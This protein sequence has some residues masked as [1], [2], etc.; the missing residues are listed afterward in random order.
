MGFIGGLAEGFLSLGR[1]INKN[2]SGDD[3]Q[4]RDEGVVSSFMD[5][6]TVD[7]DDQT[8]LESAKRWEKEWNEYFESKLQRRQDEAEN[9]W[10]GN[11]ENNRNTVATFNE[12]P[13]A[14][15][16]IFESLETFLPVATRQNPE[17]VIGSDNTSDGEKFAGLTQELVV[18]LS[19]RLRYKLK[20]KQVARHWALYYHGFLKI[21]WSE[22]TDNI[23]FKV[24]RPQKLILDPRS[25]I[26]EGFYTG[27]Y[28]GER[29]KE[30]ASVLIE[31]YPNKAKF[32]KDLVNDKLATEVAYIEWWQD[33][34]VFWTLKGEVLNKVQNPHWNFDTVITQ[35]VVNDFGEESEVEQEVKGLNHFPTPRKPY[36]ALS[37]FNSGKRPHDDTSLI[38]QNL[39]VQDIIN[40][41]VIQID[42]NVDNMNL[43]YIISMKRAGLTKEQAASLARTLRRGGSAA[44]PDG[45][46]RAA[47][48]P[49]SGA[50]LPSEVFANL[51]DMRTE[52]R[53][54]FGVSGLSPQGIAKETTARGKILVR[55]SDGDRIGG[56]IAEY[57]E[58]FS[59]MVYNWCVQMFYVYYTE[60]QLTPVLG[61]EKAKEW[62]LLKDTEKKLNVNVKEG[63]LIPKDSLT[64]RNEAIDL[65][66]AGVLDPLT[67]FEKLDFAD[68]GKAVERLITWL[69]NPQGL[70]GSD[71]QVS[72]QAQQAN[73]VPQGPQGQ[74]AQGQGA[75]TN[76]NVSPEGVP[77]PQGQNPVNLLSNVPLQ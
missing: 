15:N 62:I 42:K 3:I 17:P 34:M 45:D 7:I 46:A 35:K 43:S 40:K 77:A 68:P 4:E 65:F 29:R 61:E 39:A 59:D 30:L 50:P 36:V 16:I 18:D 57:L 58:Q 66:T 28:I 41:R 23:T 67:L 63:S 75:I 5:E 32:I 51:Q 71:N 20:L 56:G 69:S 22:E 52:L 55:G 27:E 47:I 70:L 60:E 73:Q 25:T 74:L 33:D 38:E 19:D 26:E 1:N 13:L 14:D 6:L 76:P 44:I 12:R 72:D 54:I 64:Q 11:I 49:I 37:V 48:N 8:L 31:R 21:G 2:K 24:I 9:Y 10:L 53:G